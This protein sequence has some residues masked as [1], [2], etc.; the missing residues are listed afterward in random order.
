MAKDL[1]HVI[2]GGLVESI[3][4]GDLAVV[5]WQG[6]LLFSVGEPRDK[7]TFIRSSSKPIQALTVV[8]SG[9]T[10]HFG[11]SEAEI[12]VMCASHGGEEEHVDTVRSILGKIGLSEEALQCGTHLP[13]HKPT[14]E[15][16]V[17]AGLTPT[18]IHCN[19]SGKHSGMLTL[20]RYM[21]WDIDGYTELSHPVQQ[22]MLQKMARFADIPA[23]DIVIGTDGCGVPVFGLSIYHMAKSFASL[24]NPSELNAGEQKAALTVTRAMMK[25][26]FNVAGSGRICTDLMKAAGGRVFA[27]SGAEGVYCAGVPELGIGIALKAEDGNGARCSA[28]SVVE[29]LR[30]LGVL[31]PDMLMKL[32]DQANPTLYNHRKQVIGEVKAVFTLERA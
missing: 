13:S 31:N 5:D 17:K 20:C 27:K 32:K 1:V 6:N 18:E 24:A 14:G 9:A 28:P 25:H 26:P 7:V 10:E 2:R 23:E 11:L 4:R 22:A 19:C 29:A 15:A 30:Q 12:A 21:G 16:M 8:E 3:H